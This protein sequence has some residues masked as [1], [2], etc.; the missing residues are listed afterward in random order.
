MNFIKN[1]V[2]V[3]M[4][5]SV[6]IISQRNIQVNGFGH[7]EFKANMESINTNSFFS[8]GEHDLFV[9][10]N[11]TDKVSFLGEFVIKGGGSTGFKP[12]IE[13]ARIRYNYH[14]NHFLLFG[15]MHT[16]INYWNDVY[17]H[18][19]LFF[20]TIDRPLNFSYFVPIHSLGLRLQ[21]QNLGKLNFGYDFQ[22]A[23]G[24]E[25]TDLSGSG[26]N[27]S[28][29]LSV[30][31]KPKEGMRIMIGYNNDYLP[32]NTTGS[33]AH[34]MQNHNHH[35]S[36]GITLDQIHFSFA[37]FESKFEILN[38]FATV[39]SQTDSLGKA[40][41]FTNYFYGGYRINEKYVPYF[42]F[43][44]LI[45][46][47]N[48]LHI[49]KINALKYGLGFKWDFNPMINIKLQIE[50]YGAINGFDYLPKLASKYEFK[51]QL[52]YAI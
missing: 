23:N 52:S 8:L 26:F 6:S 4:I 31:I 14:K 45:A 11:I 13:R 38:E 2:I 25:S 28:N 44:F 24:M 43:D 20:P 3:L 49:N 37:Q 35:Y 34:S 1:I 33:H 27:F 5:P 29:N 48:E 51:I 41:N 22:I 19:R 10:G 15:K 50:R 18:G 7:M 21:G 36:E 32:T 16:A 42:L 17:H 46:S 39:I 40:V 12:S 47:E 9:S 30:H